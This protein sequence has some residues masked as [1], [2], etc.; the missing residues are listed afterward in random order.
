MASIIASAT[1]AANSDPFTLT[2]GQCCT[3][4]LR[5][6]GGT[7]GIPMGVHAVVQRQDSA[8]AYLDVGRLTPDAP[9]Q[10]LQGPGTY[11]V[12]K[13]VSVETYGVDKD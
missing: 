9:V 8:A 7:R 5:M 11:R 10:L 12:L 2:D 4:A 6:T 3:L 13:P 1:A